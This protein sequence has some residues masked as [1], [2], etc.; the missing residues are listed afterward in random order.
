M[1]FNALAKDSVALFIL[2]SNLR[3]PLFTDLPS[4]LRKSD[5]WFLIVFHLNF[6]LPN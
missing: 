2:E 3:V 5:L 6:N 1:I 4:C